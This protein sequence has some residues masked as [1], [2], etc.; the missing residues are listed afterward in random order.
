MWIRELTFHVVRV[1]DI[2]ELCHI[3][4]LQQQFLLCNQ[5]NSIRTNY[6]SSLGRRTTYYYS[7]LVRDLGALLQRMYMV[8]HA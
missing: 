6:Q 4:A 1:V 7:L 8:C 3:G 5:L 2:Q